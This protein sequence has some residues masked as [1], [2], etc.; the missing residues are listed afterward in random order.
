MRVHIKFLAHGR[1]A[2]V[3]ASAY[4]LDQLDHLG[5]VRAGIEVLRGDATTFNA[6]CDSSP[7]LW[8]YTSGVI[9]WS[10]NDAPTD[11]QIKEVLDD[12]EKHAFA[13]L[14]QS[15]YHLFAVLHTDDDGSKHIHVLTPR[16]DLESG[17]SLNIAPP[18]HEK[19]FD[20]L[21]D[22]FNTKYQ[23]SRPDDL[24]WTQTT[25]EPNHVARL[26]KQARNILSSQELE[27]LPKKQFCGAIDNI[28]KTLLK[29]QIVKNRADIVACITQMGGIDSIKQSKEFLTVTLNNGKKHRLKGD[30]Y[31][32]QFEI[33]SYAA[34]LRTAA[35][36]R[37]SPSELAAALRNAEQLRAT[38]RAKRE[39]YHAQ[40]YAF[41]AST[42][43]DNSPRIA[44]KRDFERD[45]ELV[46]TIPQNANSELYGANRRTHSTVIEYRY[47]NNQISANEHRIVFNLNANI[48]KRDQQPVAE[49]R[50]RPTEFTKEYSSPS[51]ASNREQSGADRANHNEHDQ[52]EIK[53]SENNV[54][55]RRLDDIFSVDS[56]N[57]FLF[58]ISSS[59][60]SQNNRST[61]RNDRAKRADNSK[62][63]QNP[64]FIE[65]DNNANRNRPIFDRAKQLIDA[66]KQ[67][68][69]RAK[70]S[71]DS[72]SEF[73]KEHLE[74][75]QRSR[76][77]LKKQNQ[78]LA[79]RERDTTSLDF[80]TQN[81]TL[82]NR[83]GQFF[84]RFTEK[85]SSELGDT[86]TNTLNSSIE[87][88]Q[89]KQHYQQ[90]SENRAN[91]NAQNN[92]HAARQFEASTLE[93][94]T[95]RSLEHYQRRSRDAEQ[96]NRQA[97]TNTRKFNN[98]NQQLKQ[99]EKAVQTIRLKPQSAANF[100]LRNDGYYRDYVARHEQLTTRQ[101]AA[102]RSK[103][104]LQLIDCISEKSDLLNTYMN[105]ASNELHAGDYKRIN[106]I[107][108]N[109]E[110]MLKYLK[111]EAILLPQNAHFE[112]QRDKY[113]ACVK[114]F[115]NI[116][117][118]ITA[119]EEHKSEKRPV[120][121]DFEQEKPKPKN[122]F[123]LG[124]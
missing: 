46:T 40:H 17:K 16:I 116:K 15:Q 32:E 7:H 94:L 45:R 121:F 70:R 80:G 65:I 76:A 39:A 59:H 123:D 109:D 3:H 84:T 43:D 86:V 119:I 112:T 50:D 26:N 2:A 107:V 67:L 96:A 95:A 104:Q 48:K 14:E 114:T 82:E 68:A 9:A 69:S 56:F 54:H 97:R 93:D 71:I 13:G 106:D 1:G 110:R 51:T 100:D 122:D 62:S 78:Q 120:Q 102:F 64:E 12:F 55:R 19:H 38:Y 49:H 79:V 63:N 10:K 85:L 81:R 58:R 52:R 22:Y 35:E 111:C 91:T 105:R 34:A 4:L 44:S 20:S 11:E 108:K 29:T 101:D 118:Q 21:R 72:T 18:G 113:E 73:I 30:F 24:N 75:L 87:S 5:N 99:L 41:A 47:I 117:N 74:R 57:E 37:P 103:N 8:K 31:H 89:F 77:E 60:E 28:I 42:A 98:L 92:Q 124:F 83:R 23:W 25:Q 6:I 90:L 88:T 61:K 27:N 36:S 33:R 53:H 115:D 66:T